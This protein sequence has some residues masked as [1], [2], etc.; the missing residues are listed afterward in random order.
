LHWI[1]RRPI[2]RRIT[3]VQHRIC[4][5]SDTVTSQ[6]IVCLFTSKT[7]RFHCVFVYQ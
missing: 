3:N 6:N 2:D 4:P 1:I 7:R 5:V